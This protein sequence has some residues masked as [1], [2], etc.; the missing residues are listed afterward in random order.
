[1][2][3]TL[4]I[5][6]QLGG[7]YLALIKADG[8][9]V[10]W[11]LAEASGTTA[12]DSV[13]SAPGTYGGTFTLG[14][15]T[16]QPDGTTGVLLDG[17]SG[18]I[19]IA[20][21][22]ALHLGDVFTI[23]G[24]I[25]YTSTPVALVGLLHATTANA[26]SVRVDATGH[27]VLQASGGSVIVTA[28]T[29]IAD[30][31]WHHVAITKTGSVVHLYL[32]G[33]DVTGTVTNSTLVSTAAGF[34]LG[35]IGAANFF[36]GTMA[37]W[38]LYP[39]ALSS[40]QVSVHVT[41]GQWTDLTADLAST[42]M[43][44]SRGFQSNQPDDLVAAPLAWTF[45][46]NNSVHNSGGLLGFYSPDSPTVRTGWAIGI[47]MRLQITA[48]GHTRTKAYGWVEHVAP[49]A[50]KFEDQLVEVTV[51]GWL[52]LAA[53]I[54]VS[55]LA[56]AVNQRGDQL[57]ATLAAQATYPPFALAL[58]TGLD[59]YPYALDDLDPSTSH[60][61][62][63]FDSVA[64]S[65]FDRIYERADG[66][67]RY[68]SRQTRQTFT[69]AVLTITDVPPAGRPA[70]AVSGVPARRARDKQMNRFQVTVHPKRVDMTAVVLYSL[71][72]S[73]SNPTVAPGQTITMQGPYVDPN[74]QAQQVG[75]FNMLI[76][77]GMGGSTIGTSGSLPTGDLQFTTAAA[78][79]GTDISASVTV[80]VVYGANQA[81]FTITNT[82]T[83]TAFFAKLQCRGQGIYDYQ[84][85]VA[86]ATASGSQSAIGQT[87]FP[88]DC[89]YNPGALFAQSAA[90]YEATLY[91]KAVS[92]L[93]QGV[94]VFVHADDELTLD[95]LLQREIS[96]AIAISETV[97]GLTAGTYWID[98]EQLEI[99]ER[100]N[101]RVTWPLAPNVASTAWTLGVAGSSELGVTTVLG[102]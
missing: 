59:T 26:P 15:A 60:I 21:A 101:M 74:Q 20:D 37:D 81:T 54:G 25:K 97:T 87:A 83:Q 52:N 53:T 85:V 72:I 24:W 29:A 44:L 10:C 62:D 32:D 50:G 63:G 66:T 19:T 18:V 49:H 30:T 5:Q 90:T 55:G 76:S 23:E 27:L 31:T 91:S 22:A 88:F 28:T 9:T 7:D 68:E 100:V 34:T 56:A 84:T 12:A 6:A 64:K 17:T 77:D 65:G 42:A 8:A 41:A 86:T 98:G 58:A 67:L 93:D 75:G 89:P 46:L 80:S 95:T 96:D 51:A 39:T 102:F 1:M 43:H 92:Q 40:S 78:G 71:P 36:G 2:A 33:V 57:T 79:S 3:A 69:P 14:Q 94:S 70:Q 82:S 99:D 45:A 38:A 61:L 73:A 48:N 16:L 11:R 47:R 4:A 13:D 35:A